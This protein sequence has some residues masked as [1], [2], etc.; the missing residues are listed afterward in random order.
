MDDLVHALRHP[1]L[2]KNT[3]TAQSLRD[4]GVRAYSL[5][6]AGF[7]QE[8]L[9]DAGYSSSELSRLNNSSRMTSGLLFV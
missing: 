3:S 8:R 1:A 4:L 9:A 6:A 2:A 5:H 7:T